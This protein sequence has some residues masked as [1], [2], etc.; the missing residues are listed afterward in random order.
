[1]TLPR[2]I[3][4]ALVLASSAIPSAIRSEEK[5]KADRA[6]LEAQFKKADA[7]RAAAKE[8]TK[9]RADAA[10]NAMQLASDIAWLAFDA[11]KFDEAA[12]WF[13]TSAKFKEE[14]Y[15][16]ARGYWEQYLRTTAI[17]LDSKMDDQIKTQQAQLAAADDAKKPILQQL[18]HGWEKLRYLNRYNAVTMLEQIT[19][20]NNDDQRLLKYCQQELEI[21]QS[22]MAYLRKVS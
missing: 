22:E 5:A 18:I 20:D 16:N 6:T 2:F 1:M 12:T 13:E 4:V 11:T 8:N 9:E 15:L 7:D 3:F 10:K 21:R 19:R 17:E 14:S